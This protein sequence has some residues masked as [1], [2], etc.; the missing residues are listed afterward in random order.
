MPKLRYVGAI[1]HVDFPLIRRGH[2]VAPTF[3][4]H[5]PDMDGRCPEPETHEHHEMANQE[6]SEPG[7]GPLSR[8]EEFEV[9][10]DVAKELLKQVGN[11]EPVGDAL[12]VMTVDELK[13]V[14]TEK[15]V[16]LTGLTK[17]A[18][19]AAAIRKGA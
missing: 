3:V 13:A 17:K 2:E 18:D 5:S 6:L 19:I 4:C 14:A 1:D 11:F 15:G 8:G 9:S 10:D 12:D 16:D 7:V